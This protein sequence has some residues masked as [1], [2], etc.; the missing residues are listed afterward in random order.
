LTG[1]NTPDKI[2]V[3][4]QLISCL[5]LLQQVGRLRLGL[6]VC[7]FALEEADEIDY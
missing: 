6:A 1:G 5:T 7:F 3:T 4:M 2:K